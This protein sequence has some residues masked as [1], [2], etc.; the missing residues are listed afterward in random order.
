MPL[1]LLILSLTCLYYDHS[2][3][4]FLYQGIIGLV[5]IAWIVMAIIEN[6]GKERFTGDNL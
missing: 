4:G 2:Y 5:A 1:G 6:K 3:Y